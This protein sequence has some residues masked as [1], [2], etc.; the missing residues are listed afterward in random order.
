MAE[1]QQ[2][3]RGLVV[4]GLDDRAALLVRHRGDDLHEAQ[5]GERDGDDR[6]VRRPQTRW[7]LWIVLGDGL[8]GHA[9]AVGSDG[10][11][12][13]GV[14]VAAGVVE[15]Q[16]DHAVPEPHLV[17][18]A[19]VQGVRQAPAA[20][21]YLPVADARVD[22]AAAEEAVE[23]RQVQPRGH[24]LQGSDGLDRLVA[25][26]GVVAQEAAHGVAVEVADDP[27]PALDPLV[28]G[29]VDALAVDDVGVVIAHALQRVVDHLHHGGADFVVGEVEALVDPLGTGGV[30]GAPHLGAVGADPGVAALVGL[31]EVGAVVAVGP[32]PAGEGRVRHRGHG[33]VGAAAGARVH[34]DVVE[35]AAAE[36][37]FVDQGEDERVE[38]GQPHGAGL[39]VLGRVVE[40]LV[41]FGGAEG[42]DAAAD[43]AGVRF[44]N[45]DVVAGVLE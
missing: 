12:T 27:G 24:V 20:A 29:L 33:D 17:A 22:V 14:G 7:G 42:L 13:L 44:Q 35:L 32:R 39:G 2:H 45:G 26:P 30:V 40:G 8:H 31:A 41:V 38:V 16:P 5:G 43:P 10:A 28:E 1:L 3:L 36:T 9:P 25:E 18:Q 34:V 23:E 4:V 37:E 6:Q 11:G 21:G 15:L 19:L